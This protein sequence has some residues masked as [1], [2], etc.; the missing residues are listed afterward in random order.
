MVAVMYRMLLRQPVLHSEVQGGTWVSPAAAVFAEA[1]GGEEG[2]PAAM[3]SVLLRSGMPLVTVPGAVH[4]QLHEAAAAAGIELR[5]ASGAVVRAWL[6]E[7]EGA[8]ALE[9]VIF[10]VFTDADARAYYDATA[11]V[12]AAG[13]WGGAP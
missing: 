9:C 1:A 3:H 8:H 4:S 11:R 6:R 10:D 2:A 12:R 13:E 7:H 5:W